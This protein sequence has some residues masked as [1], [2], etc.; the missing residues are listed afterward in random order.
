MDSNTKK[1]SEEIRSLLLKALNNNDWYYFNNPQLSKCWEEMNCGNTECP[2]YKSPNLRCWQ[3]S[4]TFCE[5]EAQGNLAKKFD[6]CQKCKVYKKAIKGDSILQ[7]G[8]DFNIF[9]LVGPSLAVQTNK[10]IKDSVHWNFL[11]FHKD[12]D[13]KIRKYTSL[14]QQ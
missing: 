13:E 14:Y 9:H 2:S 5:G 8:E 6:D 11:F 10:F 12:I 4:G 1:L 7:I 3:V